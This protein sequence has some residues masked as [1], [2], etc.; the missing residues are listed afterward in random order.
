MLSA[1][2]FTLLMQMRFHSSSCIPGEGWEFVVRGPD[3]DKSPRWHETSD[4]PPLAARAAIRAARS[5]LGRMS[6]TEA[7]GWELAAVA[8]R[9]VAA[10]PDLWI[11]W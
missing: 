2:L 10:E 9:P 6:C 3:V 4:A 7:E 11:T 8:L 5:T 1:V